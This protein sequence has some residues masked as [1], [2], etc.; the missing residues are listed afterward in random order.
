M[1]VTIQ[2]N[3]NDF[4]KAVHRDTRYMVNFIHNMK[5]GGGGKVHFQLSTVFNITSEMATGSIEVKKK[6]RKG[7]YLIR[8]LLYEFKFWNKIK[9]NENC[10]PSQ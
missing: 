7:T 5:G 1:N 3:P 2:I 8:S 4:I 6:R 10:V 9:I